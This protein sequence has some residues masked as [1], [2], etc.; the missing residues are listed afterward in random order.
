MESH[1]SHPRI[2]ALWKVQVYDSLE[3]SWDKNEEAIGMSV[4]AHL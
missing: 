4:C 1:L 3:C 2:Q